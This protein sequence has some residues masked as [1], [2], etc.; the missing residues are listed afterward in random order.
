MK[1]PGDSGPNNGN[2]KFV[3]SFNKD[4]LNSA[5]EAG[6]IIGQR[7]RESVIDNSCNNNS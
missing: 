5:D 2:D 3:L 1:G 6:P 4:H 7:E